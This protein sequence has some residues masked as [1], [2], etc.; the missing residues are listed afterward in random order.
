MNFYIFNK[1]TQLF[2]NKLFSV[3][4]VCAFLTDNSLSDYSVFYIKNDNFVF[5]N[6]Y[7]AIYPVPLVSRIRE[8]LSDLESKTGGSKNN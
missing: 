2:E 6:I 1:Q 8:F 7:E 5:A 3:E 4:E